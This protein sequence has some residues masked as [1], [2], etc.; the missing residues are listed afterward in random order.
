MLVSLAMRPGV[1]VDA[2]SRGILGRFLHCSQ[3]NDVEF[4]WKRAVPMA[5][6]H[7]LEA[8]LVIQATTRAMRPTW[9]L[10]R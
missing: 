4:A 2:A 1:L 7:Q 5:E 6:C 8:A 10:G 3:Y 9:F